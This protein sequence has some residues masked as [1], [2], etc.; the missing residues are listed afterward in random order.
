[1]SA[2]NVKFLLGKKIGMTQLW[3]SEERGIPVTAIELGPCC[4]VQKKS[5]AKDGYSAFQI[6]FEEIAE[7]KVTLPGRGHQSSSFEISKK[8]YRH[9]CEVRTDR[10]DIEVGDILDASLF[11]QGEKVVVSAFSKGKGFQ[12]VVKRYNFGGGRKTH[13]SK[14]HRSTG[15]IGAGTDPGRVMKGKKMPGRMGDRKTSVKGL[16][17]VRIDL[18]KSIIF[19]RGSIPGTKNS[20]VS[21]YVKSA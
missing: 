13:G 7:R 20:L 15:S 10:Q 19:V 18:E 4:V 6:G 14:F 5:L 21:V 12:G 17:I 16:E 1:M 8:W 9:L 11:S 2:M 3:L